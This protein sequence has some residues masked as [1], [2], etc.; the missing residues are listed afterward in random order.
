[1]AGIYVH[2][3]FCKSR[4]IYCDFYSTK[5]IIHSHYL[6]ALVKEMN[7]Q[8]DYLKGEIIDTIY[9]GGGT[10]SLLQIEELQWIF[11]NLFRIFSIS[12]CA[13]ITIE[14]NPDDLKQEYIQQLKCLGINRLS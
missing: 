7:L 10:P 1:M 14:A 6:D 8:K 11:E 9:L 13:E 3:P 4:C 12:S 2:V 5:G